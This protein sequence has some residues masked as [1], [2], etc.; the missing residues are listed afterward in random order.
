MRHSAQELQ[1]HIELISG[2]RLPIVD[3]SASHPAGAI[4]LRVDKTI[5]PEAFRIRTMPEGIEISGDGRRG[6]LYG[7]YSLLEDVFGCRWYTAKISKIPRKPTLRVGPL[8]IEEKPAFEYREPFYFEAFNRDWAVR[9]RTNGNAQH[10]DDSIGGKV[11][12][13]PFVHTFNALVPPDTY[14]DKHPEYFSMVGGKRMKGYY[15]LCLTNPDVLKISIARV[16]EWI[17]DNPK[18]TIFS[19]SQNDTG[20]R[21][22]CDACKAV[23]AEEG[24]P[25]GR[26]APVRQRGGRRDCEGSSRCLDRHAGLPVDREAA[27]ARAPA[28]ERADSPRP[29]RRLRSPSARRLRVEQDAAGQPA[30][31]GEDHRPALHLALQHELRPLPPAS[32]RPRRDCR[33]HSAIQEKQR[34]R[35]LLRGRQCG[36]RRRRDV[37]AEGLPHGQADVGPHARAQAHHR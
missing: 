33:D 7:C 28:A 23:E 32:S 30:C 17:K 5:G 31:L 24:A 20:G 2:A 36:R 37:G 34:G 1:K 9:D 6:L 10:L 8:N 13:G 11:M 15:Q 35:H 18:A 12:Y 29:H 22:Q 26:G 19:V 16:R 25:L 21:C 14:F 3:A 4:V 27:Q